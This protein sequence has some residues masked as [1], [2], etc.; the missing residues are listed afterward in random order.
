MLWMG[1]LRRLIYI[2]LESPTEHVL[3]QI[4]TPRFVEN[5]WWN[6]LF[7]DVKISPVKFY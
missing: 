6:S 7:L 5:V 4:V 1:S 3:L 2:T